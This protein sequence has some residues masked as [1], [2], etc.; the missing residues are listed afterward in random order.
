[1]RLEQLY[2]FPAEALA[3]ALAPFKPKEVLW[4]QEEPR[5][6]GAWAHVREYWQT[7]WGY[8]HYAGRPASASP[9]VGT[10]SRH[11]AEQAEVLAAVFGD[12]KWAAA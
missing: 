6:M 2:P 11:L 1:M 7:P 9:A 3:K 5:N 12:S 8:L 10:T 4:V